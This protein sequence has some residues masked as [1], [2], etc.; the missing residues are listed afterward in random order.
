M[1]LSISPSN[2]KI[3]KIPSFSLT[4]IDSCHMRTKLCEKLCYAAKIERIY[5]NAKAAY[6]LNMA[7]VEDPGFLTEMIIKISTI[8]KKKKVKPIAFRWHVSGDILNIKYLYNMKKI[9][10]TF[11]NI[12]FYAYTRSWADPTWLPHLNILR[13]LPNFTLFA[14]LDNDHIARNVFPPKDWRVAYM[15]TW[16]SSTPMKMKLINCPEQAKK[17]LNGVKMTCETCGFC[18]KPHLKNSLVGVHFKIH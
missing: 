14:S 13:K 6:D 3:G 18:F 11:P 9:M 16:A 2:G 5:T 4:S 8:W 12:T 15:G 17:T 10:E 1:K 7:L